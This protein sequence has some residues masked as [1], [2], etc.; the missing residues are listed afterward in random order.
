VTTGLTAAI[1]VVVVVV[2]VAIVVVGTAVVVVVAGAVSA[3]H[4]RFLATFAHTS[5]CTLVLTTL[6][7]TLHE[8][9]ALF[10]ANAV[11]PEKPIR[12]I[13]IAEAR[14]FFINSV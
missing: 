5:F 9:P 6:P 13:T 10:A 3:T 14:S 8:S 7:A 1:V 2:V 12:D 11:E 4:L